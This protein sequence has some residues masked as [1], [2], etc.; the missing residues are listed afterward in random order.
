MELKPQDRLHLLGRLRPPSKPLDFH[1]KFCAGKSIFTFVAFE[2][3][4]MLMNVFKR[5]K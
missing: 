5:K 4:H 2:M 3:R 1:L